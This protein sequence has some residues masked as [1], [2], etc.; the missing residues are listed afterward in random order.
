MACVEW[1]LSILESSKRLLFLLFTMAGGG[2]GV[3]LE[4]AKMIAVRDN[5]L[6][7][8]VKINEIAKTITL[9]AMIA[10]EILIAQGKLSCSKIK[11][12][13]PGG[14]EVFRRDSLLMCEVEA[15][16]GN[17]TS[18]Q[19]KFLNEA[20]GDL[21]SNTIEFWDD[22][23]LEVLGRM[24]GVGRDIVRTKCILWMLWEGKDV[25]VEEFLMRGEGF[26]VGLFLEGGTD[27]V[28]CRLDKVLDDLKTIKELST[29]I[30]SLD[31][32][33]TKFVEERRKKEW[34][35]GRMR[36][37]VLNASLNTT[38][39]LCLQLLRL[40]RGEEAKRRRE[41]GGGLDVEFDGTYN[42]ASSED[43]EMRR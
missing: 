37:Q 27:V 38:Q 10:M 23:N 42:L 26:D 29:T 36:D 24:W 6:A 20:I 17:L 1:R 9:G 19:E 3:D 35:K 15:G 2:E 7:V 25:S 33:V 16:D 14:V 32:D 8:G 30:G 18:E 34:K 41:E 13:L 4:D 22:A 39:S 31:A 5:Y 43:V 21:C 11:E 28:C 40:K 12:V